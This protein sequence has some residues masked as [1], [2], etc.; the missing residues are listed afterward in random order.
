ME[1][2]R[3]NRTNRSREDLLP[4]IAEF[5]LD[6][7]CPPCNMLPFAFVGL[8]PLLIYPEGP[9]S[10]TRILR[11]GITFPIAFHGFALTG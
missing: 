1:E 8:V 7:S 6:L 3:V 4:P 10:K 5:M 2:E 11:A 9:V